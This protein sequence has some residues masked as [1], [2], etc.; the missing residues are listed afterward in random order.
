MRKSKGQMKKADAGP[1]R[2]IRLNERFVKQV[3]RRRL[4]LARRGFRGGA[5]SWSDALRDMI[6]QA[7]QKPKGPKPAA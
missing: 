3:E 6:I 5:V 7:S 1:I 2:A 4:Q